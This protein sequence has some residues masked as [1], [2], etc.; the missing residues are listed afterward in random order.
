MSTSGARRSDTL[1]IYVI[2]KQ[3]MWKIQHP[4]G[5]REINELHVPLGRTVKLTM[6][7]ED[8]IHDF[9]VPAFRVKKDVLPGRYTTLW[10]EPTKPGRYH[11]F[12]AQYCGA[13]HARMIGWVIV[14]EPADY[15]AW[16]SGIVPGRNPVA[17]GEKLFREMAAP[18]ATCPMAR[19]AR[20]RCTAFTGNGQLADGATVTADDAYMRESILAPEAKIVAGYQ[21]TDADVPGTD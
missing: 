2:G 17:A 13:N 8:V 15:E 11:L 12:C 20:R 3:W 4:T 18:R 6:A 16:L 14:M 10:F 21:P 5:Q 1:D 9:Y 7:S 19:A